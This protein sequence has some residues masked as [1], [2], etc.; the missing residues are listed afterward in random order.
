MWVSIFSF[1]LYEG[2]WIYKNWRYLKARNGLGIQ[3]FWRGVFGVFFCH[4][5]LNSIYNEKESRLIEQPKFSV[6]GLATGWVI[7]TVMARII[8][9]APGIE[10]TLIAAAI[11]SFLCLMPVQKYI[12]SVEKKRNPNQKM[13]GWSAGH[14]VCIV[15]GASFWIPLLNQLLSMLMRSPY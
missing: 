9:R 12:N 15:L 10:A 8:S 2:Y 4:K 13:H 3:P 14:I 11:P 6:S 1:G 5:L 7:M